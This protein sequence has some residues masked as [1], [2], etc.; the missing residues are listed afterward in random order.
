ML[1][2]TFMGHSIGITLQ[3]AF[4]VMHLMSMFD[5]LYFLYISIY[6]YWSLLFFNCLAVTV[7]P[8]YCFGM[9]FKMPRHELE[10]LIR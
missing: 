6:P 8:V 7:L 4:A 3:F 9:A 2:R 1:D 5:D 10:G